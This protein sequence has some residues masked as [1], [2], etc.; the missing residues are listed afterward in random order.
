[1]GYLGL[2]INGVWFSIGIN[3]PININKQTKGTFIESSF[4]LLLKYGVICPNKIYASGF[5]TWYILL[6]AIST[7]S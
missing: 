4:C 5:L 7:S 3:I 2:S 1:M 6:S